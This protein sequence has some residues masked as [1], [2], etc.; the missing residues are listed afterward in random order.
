MRICPC[1]V[2]QQRAG[3][4]G[5]EPDLRKRLCSAMGKGKLNLAEIWRKHGSKWTARYPWLVA[6]TDSEGAARSLGCSICSGAPEVQASQNCFASSQITADSAQTSVFDKH[7]KSKAHRDRCDSLSVGPLPVVAPTQRQFADVMEA[8]FR[9]DAEISTCGSWKFRCMLWCLAEAHRNR[10]RERMSRSVCMSVQQDVRKGQLLVKFTSVDASLECSHGVLGQVDLEEKFALDAR[11][12]FKGTVYILHKHAAKGLGR[13]GRADDPNAAAELDTSLVE[14]VRDVVE[15]FAADGA[16]DE[17]RA[18][19]LLRRFFG[20]LQVMQFDKAHAV[21]RVLSRTWPTDDFIRDMVDGLVTGPEAITQKIRYSGIFRKRFQTAVADL[22]DN[23][24]TRI[25]NLACAKHRWLSAALPFRRSVLYF[26]PLMRVAQSILDERGRRS[27]EG[28]IARAWLLRLSPEVAVQLAM[29]ADATE[30][31]SELLR[32]F[33]RD[34]YASSETT[35]QIDKFLLKATW[36]WERDGCLRTG[37]TA[38]MIQMLREPCNYRIDG[39]IHS[40]ASPSQQD[41]DRCLGRF[42]CTF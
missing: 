19:R 29:V 13:P 2:P 9:G 4:G 28:A 36:L 14:H 8:V 40:I 5:S 35:S 38:F 1:S 10:L 12:I 25:R 37:F 39:Q 26:R 30:E 11:S 3:S 42:G 23:A 31:T 21:Q 32:Y 24:K 15:L 6:V 20:N 16:Y 22:A 33:D 18:G 34:Q 17:Q 7:E 27:P 41:L